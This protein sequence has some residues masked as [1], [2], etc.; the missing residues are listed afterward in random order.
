MLS[1]ITGSTRH[2][3]LLCQHDHNTIASFH[4]LSRPAQLLFVRLYNRKDAWL[5]IERLVY[6]EV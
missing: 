4:S 3:H 1:T 2:K 5:P 6:P